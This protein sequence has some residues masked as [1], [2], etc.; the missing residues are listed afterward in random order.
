MQLV[1]KLCEEAAMKEDQLPARHCTHASDDVFPLDDNHVPFEQP[2]HAEREEAA[3]LDDHVPA[4]QSMQTS[5]LEAP[6]TVDH[7]PGKHWTQCVAPK[8]EDQ[9]PREQLIQ[10]EIDDAAT[11]DENAPAGQL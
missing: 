1:Q 11:T 6:E 3:T 5:I 9:E 4:T 7:V 8:E 10:F 2:T